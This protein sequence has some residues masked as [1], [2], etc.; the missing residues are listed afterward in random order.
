M[1]R[2]RQWCHSLPQQQKQGDMHHHGRHR[3]PP[4]N[5]V[6]HEVNVSS[7]IDTSPRVGMSNA[8]LKFGRISDIV[9]AHRQITENVYCFAVNFIYLTMIID[10]ARAKRQAKWLRY[11]VLLLIALIVLGNVLLATGGTGPRPSGA[12]V[13]LTA[14]FSPSLDKYPGLVAIDVAIVSLV[15]VAGLYR[16]VR[17]MRQFE[18]GDFFSVRAMGHLRA[19]ALLLLVA[20]VVD[21]LLPAVIMLVA[22]LAGMQEVR[23]IEFGIDGTDVWV[24]MV[25]AILLTITTAMG[26]ARK[27]A[28]DNELI[29]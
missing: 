26:E 16:L 23:S 5:R 6:S 18:Q 4:V 28:E 17:L 29:V 12:T 3:G 25:G 10:C 7:T 20:A 24:G 1:A 27:L 15:F 19:F 11:A 2:L 22:H 14:S 13:W 21:C 9:S 8:D